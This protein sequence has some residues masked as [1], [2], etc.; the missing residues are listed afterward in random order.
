MFYLSPLTSWIA[1][2]KKKKVAFDFIDHVGLEWMSSVK[3]VAMDMNSD[4][5]EAFQ[6]KCPHVEIVYDHF[7]IVKNFVTIQ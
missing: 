7:H 5:Q 3:A 4:F 6:A 2:G 1:E